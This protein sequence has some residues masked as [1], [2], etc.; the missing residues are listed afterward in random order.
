[1][2]LEFGYDADFQAAEFRAEHAAPLGIRYAVTGHLLLTGNLDVVRSETDRAGI[3]ETGVGDMR[4]G[5]QVVALKAGPRRPAVAFA[6]FA[7]LPTAS[8][9]KGLGTGRT[10]HRVL[11]LLSQKAGAVDIDFNAAWLNVARVDSNR[12]A[13]GGQA[14]ISVTYELGQKYGVEGE[15]SGQSVAGAQQR[16]VYALGAV[17]RKM[18]ERL[19]LDAGVRCG[20]GREAPRFGVFA[21][22]VLGAADFSRRP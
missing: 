22:F 9:E 11:W 16:G 15:L 13:D 14:A 20:F 17:T 3:N 19:R 2:Q 18:G 6:Y 12:R 10:D 8:K 1:L 7:K 4:I 5:L 21:G